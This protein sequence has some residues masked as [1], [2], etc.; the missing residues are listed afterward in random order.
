MAKRDLRQRGNYL[1]KRVAWKDKL[2]IANQSGTTIFS[3]GEKENKRNVIKI[4][5]KK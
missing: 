2:C 4:E 3:R 1:F 5:D